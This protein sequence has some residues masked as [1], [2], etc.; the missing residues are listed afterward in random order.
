MLFAAQSP[1]PPATHAA[2]ESA[3]D[4]LVDSLRAVAAVSPQLVFDRLAEVT[5]PRERERLRKSAFLA[6]ASSQP[7]LTLQMLPGVLAAGWIGEIPFRD[8]CRLAKV[9]QPDVAKVLMQAAVERQPELAIREWELYDSLPYAR[10]IFRQAATLAPDAAVAVASG[11]SP[12][13]AALRERLASHPLDGVLTADVPVP[14]RSRL[15]WFFPYIERGTLTMDAATA[16]AETNFSAFRA[17]AKLQG[18]ET[19]TPVAA[20]LRRTLARLAT[21]ICQTFQQSP[22]SGAPLAAWEPREIYLLLAY[23]VP[24]DEDKYFAP[25]FDRYLAPRGRSLAG[26]LTQ[27]DLILLSSLLEQALGARR[28]DAFL[29]L[30]ASDAE[31]ARWIA[32]LLDDGLNGAFVAADVI[33]NMS[34]AGRLRAFD[35]LLKQHATGPE[36][37]EII[38]A[39]RSRLNARLGFAKNPSAQL[40]TH[41][42]FNREGLS[43]QRHLFY[44]DADGVESFESF[45]AAYSGSPSWKWEDRGGWILLTGRRNSREIRI[46]ANVP[47]DSL[48]STNSTSS[49]EMARRAVSEYITA[50][51]LPVSVIVHRGHSYHVDHTINALPRSARLVFLG[52]CRGMSR[53][54]EVVERSP[55]AAVIA[56]RATGTARIND[57]LLKALNEALLRDSAI[58]WPVFWS[59]Q[60]ARF[61][62]N[63]DFANYI[64]PHRNAA[65][66][67][68]RELERVSQARMSVTTRP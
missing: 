6:A 17:L 12:S 55:R 60:R 31:A 57:A 46:V 56:T 23:S 39:L 65:V 7:E 15:A 16:A 34:G 62:G 8:A 30:A 33:E 47:V 14:V 19:E 59:A 13:A 61:N 9:A 37:M 3:Q 38:A 26:N 11:N 32:Q 66:E 20:M 64:P 52:S 2:A 63:G 45:R 27:P 41:S 40:S 28:L 53:M 21:D 18:N 58:D 36:R 5:S 10:E 68:A 67:F 22:A 44:D 49:A 24:Q 48:S 1:P 50:S 4:A 35:T 54:R 51:G 42:L 29:N 25:I 43:L